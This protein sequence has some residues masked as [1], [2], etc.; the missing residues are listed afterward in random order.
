MRIEDQEAW[1][2][3]KANVTTK[4]TK[5]QYRLLC[6]LHARY[7]NHKY[8]EPCSC[9]PKILVMWIKDIDNIYNKI[10]D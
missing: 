3:F 2:D 7:F 10:N 6:T 8:H 9:K 1:I 5:D 4:L